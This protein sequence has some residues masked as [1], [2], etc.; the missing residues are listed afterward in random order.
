LTIESLEDRRLLSVTGNS[1]PSVLVHTNDSSL[2]SQIPGLVAGAT[3][4]Q[5]NNTQ[6]SSASVADFARFDFLYLGHQAGGTSGIV[7]SKNTWAQAITGRAAIT[8]VHFEHASSCNAT[9]GPAR[10]LRDMS[11]WIHSGVGTGLLVSSTT[12]P[13]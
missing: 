7:N 13:R 1:G 9:A 8:G 12:S 5:W 6:W 4:T 11:N 3:V 2:A 10:V